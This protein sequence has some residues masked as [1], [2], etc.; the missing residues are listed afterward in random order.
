M[1]TTIKIYRGIAIAISCLALICCLSNSLLG[2]TYPQ[3]TQPRGGCFSISAVTDTDTSKHCA[4]ILNGLPNICGPDPQDTHLCDNCVDVTICFDSCSNWSPTTIQIKDHNSTT[5]C[6]EICAPNGDFYDSWPGPPTPGDLLDQCSWGDPRYMT[7][8]NSNGISPG[9]CIT[10]RICHN[11]EGTNNGNH[12]TYDI[13][14][15][16][17]NNGNKASPCGTT[18]TPPPPCTGQVTF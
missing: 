18:I 7:Y 14:V 17:A 11:L 10:F 9:T 2:Q 13:K 3:V 4:Y 8:N 6:H 12:E 1:K 16:D 15:Y 5:D